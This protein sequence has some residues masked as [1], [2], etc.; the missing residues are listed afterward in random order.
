MTET[1]REAGET[2][3]VARVRLLV[4]ML[5]AFGIRRLV[6]WLSPRRPMPS[7]YVSWECDRCEATGVEADERAANLALVIHQDEH[8]DEPFDSDR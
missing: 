1:L 6:E 3:H 5:Q 2:F 4:I 8:A 7:T